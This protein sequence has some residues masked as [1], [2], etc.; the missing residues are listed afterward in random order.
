VGI[1]DNLVRSSIGIESKE[2]LIADNDQALA[3]V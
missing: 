1:Y 3:T 2:D